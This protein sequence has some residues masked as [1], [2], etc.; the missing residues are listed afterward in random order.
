MPE[1]QEA[2]NYDE[3]SMKQSMLFSDGLKAM[4]QLSPSLSI[5]K[6]KTYEMLLWLCK[7]ERE[8]RANRLKEARGTL[9]LVKW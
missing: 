4:D 1:S 3:V 9:C 8:K 5:T 7:R 2:S 6:L